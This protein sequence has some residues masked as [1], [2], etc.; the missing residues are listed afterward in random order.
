M[1][2]SFRS[3]FERTSFGRADAGKR[4][5][6]RR[7]FHRSAR[8]LLGA[9]PRARTI[10]CSRSTSSRPSEIVSEARSPRRTST[11]GAPGPE[12]RPGRHPGLSEETL[13]LGVAQD[14]GSFLPARGLQVRGRVVL[15]RLLA[16]QVPVEG[17]QARRLAVDGRGR[18]G[19]SAVAVALRQVRQEVG[20][21]A[22][23]G[24]GRILPSLAEEAAELQQVGPVGGERVPREPRSNSRWARKSSTSAS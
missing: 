16:S 14:L 2:K 4:G 23:L 17:A 8:P 5:P 13:D 9:L 21:V 1:R 10:P 18:A 3:S 7:P 20:E 19:R 6:R 22:R 11:R 12:R 24:G 15:D